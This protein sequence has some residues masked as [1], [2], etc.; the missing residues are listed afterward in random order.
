RA[1][2][3]D[4]TVAARAG[5]YASSGHQRPVHDS[6][7]PGPPAVTAPSGRRSGAARARRVRGPPAAAAPRVERSALRELARPLGGGGHRRG[8]P[9]P[10]ALA[11][12]GR[13]ALRGGAAPPAVTAP[14]GRRSGAAG[15]RRVRGPPA[16]AAPRVERSALRELARPL[17]G[18]GH[19]RGQPG[20]H[21]LALEGGVALRGG[22][23]R[24]AHPGLRDGG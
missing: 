14:S 15:A 4:G 3:G 16:A 11:L 13:V 22:A 1:G 6:T 23:A 18:G 5:I 12:E 10:H 8:Q 21:A 9:G 24:A 7:P 19:R 2:V 17:G 20:P